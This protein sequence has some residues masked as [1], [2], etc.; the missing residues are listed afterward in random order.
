M[1]V[2]RDFTRRRVVSA[3]IAT[4][5]V[6]PI[7]SAQRAWP[8]ET[9][10]KGAVG[11][12]SSVVNGGALGLIP[13]HGQDQSVALQTAIDRTAAAG[14]T[15]RLAPGAYLVSNIILR[16]GTRI[17]GGHGAAILAYGGGGS[18]LAGRQSHGVHLTGLTIDGGRLPLTTARA[19][20]DLSDA[21]SIDFNDVTVR[22]SAQDGIALERVSGTIRRA[23]IRGV[24]GTAIFSIDADVH[25][26]AVT[27]ADAH[28]AEAADNGILIW[29]S[30]PGEDGSRVTNARIARIGNVSGG[31]GQYGNG[32][33]VYRAHG[34]AVVNCEIRECAYSAIRGNAASNIQMLGNHARDIG[35]VALY[36]EFGFQG[37]MI[38]N[39]TVDTAACGIA[40]TNFDHGGRLAVVQG[41]LIRNLF[42][43]DAEPVDKRGEGIAVEADAAITGNVVEGAAAAGVM[44]GWGKHMRDVVATGNLVRDARFGIAVSTVVGAG[45]CLVAHNLISGAREGAIRAMD[46]AI[47]V[48]D[49][50]ITGMT[51]GPLTILGNAAS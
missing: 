46:H 18:M 36:A 34:V 26:G 29:R 7:L 37:A 6:A 48:G 15:L 27:I 14:L 20:I 16:A 32:V 13:G 39:N 42:R 30:N 4:S 5:L 3:G 22:A 47:P 31:S 9:S 41:N 10:K 43:R 2:G 28:I 25:A 19:L 23:D 24:G 35:E 8:A 40:A 44:I 33:N 50:L 45:R 17:D 21:R 38:A 11:P 51:R 1:I 49:D 12:G